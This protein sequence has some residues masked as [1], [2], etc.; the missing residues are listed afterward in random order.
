MILLIKHII[1]KKKMDN[2][3]GISI[4]II[5]PINRK[6]NEEFLSFK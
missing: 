2:L 6:N 5:I 1:H 3:F 4:G